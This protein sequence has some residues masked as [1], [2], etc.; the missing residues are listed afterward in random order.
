MCR[1]QNGKA[2]KGRRCPSHT[3]PVLV[4][5]RNEVRREQYANK[6]V[7]VALAKTL[8]ESNVKFT[9]GKDFK[10]TFFQGNEFLEMDKFQDPTDS[11]SIDYPDELLAEGYGPPLFFKPS[12]GG[13]WT[14]P[15]DVSG[16]EVKT[17]WTN[18]AYHED[19]RDV[20]TK[21]AEIKV[22]PHAVI[23]TID[24]N[25][26]VEALVKAFPKGK[27]GQHGFSFEKMKA[28]GID[29]LHL[30]AEGN[31]NSKMLRPEEKIGGF[32][33]WD[34]ESTV[35]LRKENIYHG[36]TLNKGSY[37]PKEYE[38]YNGY[39]DDYYDDENYGEGRSPVLDINGQPYDEEEVA[40]LRAKLTGDDTDMTTPQETARKPIPPVHLS[41]E[42]EASLE[43]LRARLRG[44]DVTPG[45][46]PNP[47]S[48]YE[49]A[50]LRTKLMGDE[51][52]SYPAPLSD[53]KM[54][55]LR[56]KLMG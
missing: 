28:A 42:E 12:G 3:D 20:D 51:K 17:A 48:D 14:S 54:A 5:E 44:E 52:E 21:I 19:F 2:G 33:M 25:D 11:N 30:S 40:K 37:E 47:L 7:S 38:G 34:M 13:L 32:S 45:D 15:G 9:S 23:V 1:V 18:W 4:E 43:Y 26:D 35:W 22:R 8:K 41:S 53:D 50:D 46:Y 56:K 31:R 16:K 39:D 49:M 36:Q 24:H 27:D 55:E 29:G 6:K 10:R